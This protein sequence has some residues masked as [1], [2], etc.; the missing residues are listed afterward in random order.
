MK[1]KLY[2]LRHGETRYQEE[3]SDL[4]Y[5]REDSFSL[6]IT[7]KAKEKI[8]KLIPEIKKE[9][10]DLIYA[11]DFKRTM[12]TARIVFEGIGLPEERFFLSKKLRDTDL[13]IYHGKT[14]DFFYENF[15]NF[16]TDFSI[17]PEEGESMIDSRNRVISFLEE[18]NE[19]H[20][21]KKILIVSHGDMLWLLEGIIRKYRDDEM[22]SD[23]VKKKYMFPGE[24]RKLN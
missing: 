13:G 15:P 20:E 5:S 7:D 8:K 19:K 14:K 21:N 3:N 4:T 2:I 11:S 22:V 17:R 16:M 10:I 6:G 1:N 23:G 12:E 24:F 18:I 9:S